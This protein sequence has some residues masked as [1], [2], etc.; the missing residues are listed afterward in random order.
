MA[1]FGSFEEIPPAEALS[2]T[3]ASMG[4]FTVR[5]PPHQHEVLLRGGMVVG[6]RE[7][8]QLLADVMQLHARIAELV[9]ARDGTFQFRRLSAEQVRG[10]F[11][12]PLQQILASGLAHQ[13]DVGSAEQLP[14]PRTVFER[15]EHRD[16]WLGDEL[17]LFW[18]RAEV[19]LRAGSHAEGLAALTGTSVSKAQQYL[20]RLRLAG[21]VR[22]RRL[23][24]DGVA[25]WQSEEL[26]PLPALAVKPAAAAPRRPDPFAQAD[27]TGVRPAL[28]SKPLVQRLMDGLAR[29]FR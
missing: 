7:N 6:W 23:P 24:T 25:R 11:E 28:P 20:H 4:I 29:W 1:I 27:L 10:P 13:E 15:V 18:E 12:I 26:P 17:Q 22:V 5:R 21:M 2:A 19:R 16:M 8:G 9:G 3:G 14:S